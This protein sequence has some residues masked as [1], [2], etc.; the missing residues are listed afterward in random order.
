MNRLNGTI[1][2]VR[3]ELQPRKGDLQLL[4]AVLAVGQL[5][6]EE[7]AQL[8]GDVIDAYKVLLQQIQEERIRA[9]LNWN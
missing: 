3:A 2:G 5:N 7:E 8:W 6:E 4:A 9:Q 1:R